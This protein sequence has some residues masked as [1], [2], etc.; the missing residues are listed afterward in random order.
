MLNVSNAMQRS[1]FSIRD[2]I[3]VIA[4]TALLIA[5]GRYGLHLTPKVREYRRMAASHARSASEWS[6]YTRLSE[7]G[8]TSIHK[9][10]QGRSVLTFNHFFPAE[11][12]ASPEAAEAFDHRCAEIAAVCRARASYHTNMG[13]KWQRAASY[14]W[15]NALPDPPPP[16]PLDADDVKDIAL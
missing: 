7:R 10:S 3:V 8:I 11:R 1:Q 5:G 6:E 9:N 16:M 4:I 14:P 12:P 13:K 2:L 15:V